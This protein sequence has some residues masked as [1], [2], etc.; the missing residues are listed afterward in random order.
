MREDIV[1][2]E[3]AHALSNVL[4]AQLETIATSS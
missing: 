2:N 3:R 4:I 1:L